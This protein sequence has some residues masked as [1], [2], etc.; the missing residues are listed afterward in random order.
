MRNKMKY[1]F[2]G[3]G[4]VILVTLGGCT[5]VSPT[6]V[7]TTQLSIQNQSEQ[8][9]YVTAVTSTTFSQ[10]VIQYYD[11]I[12]SSSDIL[13]GPDDYMFVNTFELSQG[14]G[15]VYTAYIQYSQGKLSK[16][17]YGEIVESLNSAA[18]N[19]RT[20][21]YINA[22]LLTSEPLSVKN[23]VSGYIQ[24]HDNN[25]EI[26]YI[27]YPQYVVNILNLENQL[28][29]QILN[30]S[31]P[32]N[33]LP[34]LQR[35]GKLNRETKI[36]FSMVKK[37]EVLPGNDSAFDT[38]LEQNCDVSWFYPPNTSW[39]LDSQKQFLT[40]TTNIP[41]YA[42]NVTLAA[43]NSQFNAIFNSNVQVTE[44]NG[45]L[46]DITADQ[47]EALCN[48]LYYMDT[49]YQEYQRGYLT[50]QNFMEIVS[51]CKGSF[52]NLYTQFQNTTSQLQ[53]IP[54]SVQNGRTMYN[55]T[56]NGNSRSINGAYFNYQEKMFASVE[57]LVDAN[58][59]ED[60]YY[61]LKMAM[62]YFKKSDYYLY[63]NNGKPSVSLKD[64]SSQWISDNTLVSY[65]K[66]QQAMASSMGLKNNEE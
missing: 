48:W 46:N 25:Q 50:K 3:V 28:G 26:Q 14:M 58:D 18:Q 5:S 32:E 6:S 17:R 53:S 10:G 44:N 31:S 40:Q 2:L 8:S 15:A 9:K 36:I 1:G 23:G 37:S 51:N 56:K 52:E 7:T 12:V 54:I 61:E 49:A 64:Y 62:V 34:L 13:L 16:Q 63:R 38:I 41:Y 57:N 59:P 20:Q 43:L 47:T 4:A 42:S 21:Y 55:F 45:N 30:T 11:G 19:L 39:Y 24:K 60:A 27:F 29:S 65:S 66:L 33:V 22:S 35:F